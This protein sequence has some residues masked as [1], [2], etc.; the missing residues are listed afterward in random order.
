MAILSSRV[1]SQVVLEETEFCFDEEFQ[2]DAQEG[3]GKAV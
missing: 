2:D 1:E 3:H